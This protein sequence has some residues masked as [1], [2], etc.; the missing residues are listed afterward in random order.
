[1]FT[2]I[3]NGENRL[4]IEFSGKLDSDDMRLALD[5]LT[6]KAATIQHGVMLY[7]IGEFELPTVGAIGVELSRLPS[8][9]QLIGKFDKAAVLASQNWVRIASQIE[10]MLI[11]GL[12][13]KAF[14]IDEEAQAEAWLR[15][16]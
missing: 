8:L 4:D 14:D 10:G 15:E 12:E 16:G 3:P 9:F 7:R 13:I 11:P 6:G 2:V 5:E 1:M